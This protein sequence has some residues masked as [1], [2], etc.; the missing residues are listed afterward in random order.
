M[1]KKFEINQIKIK[2]S[3]QLGRKVATHDSKSDL[4]LAVIFDSF[5]HR[6]DR[7]STNLLKIRKTDTQT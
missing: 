3:C 4:P 6:S 1:D 5:Y 7:G 2:G